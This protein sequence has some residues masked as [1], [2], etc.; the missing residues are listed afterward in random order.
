MKKLVIILYSLLTGIVIGFIG[1]FAIWLKITDDELTWVDFNF[2][3]SHL[4]KYSVAYIENNFLL[5]LFFL[6]TPITIWIGLYI[7]EKLDIEK[8]KKEAEE[9]IK[10]EYQE[11]EQYKKNIEKEEL[12]I[13]NLKIEANQEAEN[14]RKEAY[15]EGFNM[16]YEDGQEKN[17]QELKKLRKIQS[18]VKQ[19]FKDNPPLNECFK[20]TTGWDFD[21]WIKKLKK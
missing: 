10:K 12:K 13:I 21:V 4:I 2:Y 6:T 11:L 15:Y 9:E 7:Y 14:I 19:I 16:G 1:L 3:I 17:K 5:V 8:K 18:A 20:K